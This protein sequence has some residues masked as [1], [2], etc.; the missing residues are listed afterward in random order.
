M[1]TTARQFS[2]ILS[3]MSLKATSFLSVKRGIEHQ[4]FQNFFVCDKSLHRHLKSK[5]LTML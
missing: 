5:T 4:S 2:K 3:G 1:L